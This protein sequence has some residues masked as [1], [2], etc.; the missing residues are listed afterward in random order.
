MSTRPTSLS[1][2]FSDL[3]LGRGSGGSDR[4]KAVLAAGL[5]QKQRGAASTDRI[6]PYNDRVNWSIV[7]GKL[8]PKG[9]KF[10][11]D[12]P[13]SKPDC[14]EDKEKVPIDPIS[15]EE[16]KEGDNIVI[17]GSGYAYK[18]ATL[19]K[20]LVRRNSRMCI[21][22]TDYRLTDE[23]LMEIGLED[24]NETIRYINGPASASD[25]G[26]ALSDA[27]EH[28]NWDEA[29]RLIGVGANVNYANPDADY[30]T[31]LMYACAYGGLSTAVLLVENGALV[32]FQNGRGYTALHWATEYQHQ[33]IVDYLL[34][35]PDIDVQI[36]TES[37]NGAL[38]IA[39]SIGDYGIARSLLNAGANVG[40]ANGE[41]NTPLMEASKGGHLTIVTMLLGKGA[42]ANATNA[43]GLT[44]LMFSI[45]GRVAAV[46]NALLATD[47]VE[48]NAV[49]GSGRSALMLAAQ[50]TRSDMM[51]MLIEVGADVNLADRLGLTALMRV[52]NRN[53][54]ACV[55]LLI[56]AGVEVE[57]QNRSGITSLMF[58]SYNG[59]LE[60]VAELV[61][62]GNADVNTVG[63]PFN[64]RITA[65]SRAVSAN[66]STVV[67]YL[68]TSG[69]DVNFVD[70][71]ERS[72]LAIAV[73]KGYWAVEGMLR[74]AGATR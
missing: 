48:V 21:Y 62:K 24:V 26:L 14:T 38:L 20:W 5:E 32:N 1:A 34:S 36:P 47:T 25:S 49:D 66:R 29:S 52:A 7:R 39:C 43:V 45:S 10:T 67:Q 64:G 56:A 33:A 27:V 40:A 9:P 12:C 18:P 31:P 46:T 51:K 16:F 73:L 70:G 57:P 58:A 22:N 68:I 59:F 41:E 61:T 2:D 53:G 63:T 4:L 23:E 69:A 15:R 60:I 19:A 74:E 30:V 55:R 42:N 6:V 65:L 71:T 28:R 37:G 72:M 17:I 50:A 54:L 8:Y 35:V 3:Q 44:A 11:V 13:D